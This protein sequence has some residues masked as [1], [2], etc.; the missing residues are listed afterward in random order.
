MRQATAAVLRLAAR[1]GA[2]SRNGGGDLIVCLRATIVD[3]LASAVPHPV[4]H[5]TM[6]AAWERARAV[7]GTDR[8][9]S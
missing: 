7:L 6:H 9:G 1:V 5:P 8:S 2:R 3:M 4:E